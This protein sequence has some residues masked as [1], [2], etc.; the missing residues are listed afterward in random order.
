[1]G[2]SESESKSG[3]ESEGESEVTWGTSVSEYKLGVVCESESE[4]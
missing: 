2:E 1:M 3:G 4:R